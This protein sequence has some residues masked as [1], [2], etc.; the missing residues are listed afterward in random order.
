MNGQVRP[1]APEEH[2]L[3]NEV[4]SDR[5]GI[6]FPEEKRELLEGKLLPR[7]KALRL[8]RFLDY[9]LTLQYDLDSE[10]EQLARQ[11]TNNE[12]YFFREVYHFDALF[13]SGLDKLGAADLGR[14][15]RVLCAGCSSG[16][17]PFTLSI[18]AREQTRSGLFQSLEI[19]AFDIDREQL[20]RAREAAY[21]PNSLRAA[22]EAQ[23]RSYFGRSGAELYELHSRF[24]EPVSF[25]CGNILDAS[26][27]PLRGPYDIIFCRNVLIYFSEEAIHRTLENFAQSLRP[28]G[29]LFL[30]HSESIIGVSPRF[31]AIRLSRCIAY[32][33]V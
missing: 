33:R 2:Q 10:L 30:G 19:D 1:L 27:Y 11:V 14:P 17:E 25:S 4:I 20:R 5:L 9:Y 22:S 23:I 24:R 21:G 7:L 8:T 16:E 18:L 29:V 26:T 3:L 28:G 15:L 32:H 31:E 6:S 12:T 13:E